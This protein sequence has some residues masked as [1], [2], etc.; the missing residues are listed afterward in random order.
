MSKRAKRVAPW[1]AVLDQ[2]EAALELAHA[3]V[4][5][6]AEALPASGAADLTE[7]LRGEWQGVLSRIDEHGEA[8]AR[9][10]G[11]VAER[12]GELAAFLEGEEHAC[13]AWRAGV[14]GVGEKFTRL[15]AHSVS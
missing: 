9:R 7:A 5:A 12:M 4:L 8:V 2:V 1:L 13:R 10:Q 11:H 15:A 6:R 3:K 14:Q